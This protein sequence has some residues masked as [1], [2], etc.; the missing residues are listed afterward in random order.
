VQKQT[1]NNRIDG[2]INKIWGFFPAKYALI[3][4]REGSNIVTWPVAVN[5]HK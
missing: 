5:N 1:K 3:M 4:F 2:D